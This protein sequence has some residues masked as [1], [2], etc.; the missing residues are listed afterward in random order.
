MWKAEVSWMFDKSPLHIMAP[1]FRSIKN[2]NIIFPCKVTSL[3][4]VWQIHT[5]ELNSDN[6]RHGQSEDPPQT[7]FTLW[8]RKWDQY[9]H[10]GNRGKLPHVIRVFSS[11]GDWWKTDWSD[12]GVFIHV[13]GPGDLEQAVVVVSGLAIV[14]GVVHDLDH[15]PVY[16]N[17]FNI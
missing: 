16:G 8:C 17:V 6:P 1:N 9:L 10:A 4:N 3:E 15:F 7:D 12:V 2:N 13:D 14:A 5:S 11:V